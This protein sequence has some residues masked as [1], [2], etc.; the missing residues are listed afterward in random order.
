[1][2]NGRKGEGA[3]S[4]L[5]E[6][7]TNWR[8]TAA[9]M[10]GMGFGYS[11][12]MYSN[13]IFGPPLLK[14]FGWSKAQFALLGTTLL[15]NVIC[16]PAIGRL[17]DLLGVRKV[18]LI[19]FVTGPLIFLGLSR[20]SG[21]FA[22]FLTLSYVLAILFGTTTS[23]T[24]FGRLVAQRFDRARGLALSLM[25]CAPAAAAAIATPILGAM[26]EARGWRT[27]Y[28]VLAAVTLAAGIVALLLVPARTEPE[29]APADRA[30]SPFRDYP[31][32][33]RAPTFWTLIIAM[34]LCNLTTTV[35]A[36][37]LKLIL[38]DRAV[39]ADRATGMISLYIAGMLVGRFGSGLA[40]DR[41]PAHIVAGVSMALPAAGIFIL[42][43]ELTTPLLLLAAVS[44]VGMVVGA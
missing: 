37:Q 2:H 39:P 44:T 3:L 20:M 18:A 26:I 41:F 15:V 5:G 38:L 43:S 19:G 33:L 16:L 29:K 1:M 34:L 17:T 10:I 28:V 31:E 12:Y 14:E 21:D 4:Y 27:S 40:L 30:A 11:L 24:V 25:A 6:L 7:R 36:S 22:V 32:I 42:A 9:A 8:E 23:S 13:A 35:F